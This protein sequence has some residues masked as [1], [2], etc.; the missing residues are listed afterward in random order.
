MEAQG[1]ERIAPIARGWIFDPAFYR[2]QYGVNGDDAT[3]YR[4]WLHEG[5]PRGRSPNEVQAIA[6]MLAGKPYPD[7]F[8]WQAYCRLHPIEA[9]APYPARIVALETLFEQPVDD[10]ARECIAGD[11]AGRLFEAIGSYHL[12]RARYGEAAGAFRIAT[13]ASEPTARLHLRLGDALK[14]Q[15]DRQGALASYRH[16]LTLPDASIWALIH[17]ANIMLSQKVFRETF[18]LVDAN[19]ERSARTNCS[20]GSSTRSPARPIAPSRT[21]CTP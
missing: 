1:I 17:A 6:G 5:F 11:G 2:A 20:T 12:I 10:Q 16:A 19:V 3:L 8:D 21:R 14:G 4:D 13:E 9:S 7:C 15:G 18:E